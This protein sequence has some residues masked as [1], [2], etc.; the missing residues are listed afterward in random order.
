MQL[1]S[2][3]HIQLQRQLYDK[4]C[5]HH[6]L[7]PLFQSTINVEGG[8]GDRKKLIFAII[9]EGEVSQKLMDS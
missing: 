8:R 3:M 5:T 9:G 6:L 7:G 4:Q 1:A 2:H